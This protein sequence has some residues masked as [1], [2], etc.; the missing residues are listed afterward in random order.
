MQLLL[1]ISDF[2]G[3]AVEKIGRLAAWIA[4]AL[5]AVIL[6]DVVSRRFF[7]MGSSKLQELEWHFHTVLFMFCLGIGYIHDTHVRIDMVREKLGRRAQCW[8]EILG[9]VLFLIPFCLVVIYFGAELTHR[10]W[11]KGEISSSATG[12]PFRWLIKSAI[13]IGMSVLLLSAFSVLLRRIVMLFRPDL[14][15]A[16]G[17]VDPLDEIER[18]MVRG[19]E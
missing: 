6:F 4:I 13:P 3:D 9:C 1:K 12:L 11:L 7:A 16:D 10:S 8:I 19:A 2:L 18:K 15:R 17:D 14:C 5:I